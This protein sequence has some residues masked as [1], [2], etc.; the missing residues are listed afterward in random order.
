MAVLNIRQSEA[1]EMLERYRYLTSRQ[2]SELGVH[3]APN[4]VS[5]KVL[6]PLKKMG[7][8]NT[9]SCGIEGKVGGSQCML[10][11]LK[12][13]SK[14]IFYCKNYSRIVTLTDIHIELDKSVKKIGAKL[15]LFDPFF[16]GNNETVFILE[17]KERDYMFLM[18]IDDQKGLISNYEQDRERLA[19]IYNY[20]K[21]PQ[22]LVITIGGMYPYEPTEGVYIAL[23]SEVLDTLS[24]IIKS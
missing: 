17:T 5:M 16:T 21:I 9:I 4:L 13:Y 10:N 20:D 18:G 19:T 1:L 15:K 12:Q 3:N 7:L 11:R 8:I 2:F 23:P 22:L 14:E 6:K 24:N